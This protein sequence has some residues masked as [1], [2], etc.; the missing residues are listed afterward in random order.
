MARMIEKYCGKNDIKY[1]YIEQTESNIKLRI[2][3]SG[4]IF[5]NING[6]HKLV[7]ISPFGKGN[8]IHT[9]LCKLN[10]LSPLPEFDIKINAKD[11]RMDFYKSTGPGGQHK[12]K[13]MSAVRLLHIPTNTMVTSDS[14]RSQHENREYAYDLLICKLGELWKEKTKN[15]QI[16]KR[17][18][19][20]VNEDVS[21]SYYFNHQFAI[22]EIT[23]VKTTL[24][25]S[26][27]N[28][29]LELILN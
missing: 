2:E 5:K 15:A 23:G 1:E 10:L 8:K 13:T 14:S 18:L 9:S 19:A 3:A 4:K 11:I 21:V 12:N 25:K 27:F 20:M 28:G 24:I 17:K 22:N 16:M 7:R 26:L 6:L 29:E